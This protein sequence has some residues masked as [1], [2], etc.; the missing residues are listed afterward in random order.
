VIV[1]SIKDKDKRPFHVG[2]LQ[3]AG[4]IVVLLAVLEQNI[5]DG[6]WLH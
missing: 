5:I 6:M 3:V 4:W 2:Q 1:N